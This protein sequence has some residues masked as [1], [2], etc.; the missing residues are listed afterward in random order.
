MAHIT[1]RVIDGA[2]RGIEYDSIETPITIGR[3]EG[4][5]VQLNDERISRF[6]I[7]IQEDQGKVVLTDLESTN[8]TR[9]NGEV[10]Q[11]RI[12]RYGDLISV[13]R[14]VLI[15]GTR[16]QIADRLD[17]LRGEGLL[18]TDQKAYDNLT[19]SVESVMSG[20]SDIDW[21]DSQVISGTLHL[22]SPPDLPMGLTPGQAAQFSEVLEYLHLRSR[23]LVQSTKVD[24]EADA[25]S[26]SF[27]RWQDLLDQQAH[28]A[29]YL[30]KIGDPGEE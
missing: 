19:G 21:D 29:E 18:S 3:E 23:S 25:V 28:L 20:A 8:G 15:Y 27:E 30:R 12:L 4:N 11:L 1:L 13:G 9:V 10:T 17:A 7:K 24:D 26:I 16:E 22:P 14:S 5:G 2:D 6:H